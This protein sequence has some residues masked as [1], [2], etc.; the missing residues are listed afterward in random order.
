MSVATFPKKETRWTPR[1][2][3]R[4]RRN[5][6]LDEFASLLNVS[7]EEG[8]LWENGQSEPDIAQMEKLSELA[9]REQFLKNW[10]LAGSGELIG[11][12]DVASQELSDELA[13]SLDERAR[14]LQE[15]T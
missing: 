1:L 3:K 7:V 10:K 5:R 12:L 11:D 4:L 9:E 15:G 2:I 8:A 14:R 6:S 13:H